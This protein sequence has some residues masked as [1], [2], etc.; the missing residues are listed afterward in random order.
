MLKFLYIDSPANE[1]TTISKI[2]IS[3]FMLVSAKRLLRKMPQRTSPVT[4]SAKIPY[5]I[6]VNG[7]LILIR[8]INPMTH[9]SIVEAVAISSLGREKTLPQTTSAPTARTS[10]SPAGRAL[11]NTFLRK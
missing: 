11:S 1:K 8:I 7:L 9:K 10:A 6:G 2:E 5:L 4:L 3:D